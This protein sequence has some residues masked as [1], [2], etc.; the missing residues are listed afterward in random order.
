MRTHNLRGDDYLVTDFLEQYKIIANEK[1]MG[2]YI[3]G[4]QESILIQ[5]RLI[6]RIHSFLN[7]LL[8]EEEE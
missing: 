5:R 2:L 7:K 3:K 1:S 4:A 8:L 6:N